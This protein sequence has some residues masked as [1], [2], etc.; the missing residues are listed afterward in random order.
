MSEPISLDV[1]VHSAD[2]YPKSGEDAFGNPTWG[3]KVE[4]TRIRVSRSKQTLLTALGEAKN[5]KL[6]LIFDCTNSLPAGTAFG[7]GDK[8]VY[9]SGT[10]LACEVTDNSGDVAA[11]HHYRVA[12]VGS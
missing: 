2:L 3:E 9:N 1:L 4:L 8:I 12:L 7:E 10:Y 6:V 11:A 5:D